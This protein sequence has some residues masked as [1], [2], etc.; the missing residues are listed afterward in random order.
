MFQEQ[1]E[2]LASVNLEHAIALIKTIIDGNVQTGESWCD[3]LIPVLSA[4]NRHPTPSI[5]CTDLIEL[6]QLAVKKEPHYSTDYRFYDELTV[7]TM[8]NMTMLQ[9]DG[10]PVSVQQ[11]WCQKA[12]SLATA[13]A[14]NSDVLHRLTSNLTVLLDNTPPPP[15]PPPP[16]QPKRSFLVVGCMMMKNESAI[17]T[18]ALNDLSPYVDTLFVVDTGSTDNSVELVKTH[19]SFQKMATAPIPSKLISVPWVN[20]GV[21]R[22]EILNGIYAH[23]EDACP[24]IHRGDL[25]AVMIDVDDRIVG[26]GSAATFR[27]EL[28]KLSEDRPDVSGAHFPV[29]NG[30]LKFIRMQAFRLSFQWKYEGALH[31]YPVCTSTPSGDSSPIFSSV[32]LRSCTSGGARSRNPFKY[33]D[34]AM[35][36]RKEFGGSNLEGDAELCEN[37]RS[38]FYLAQSFRDAGRIPAAVRFYHQRAFG[39]MNAGYRDEVDCSLQNLVHLTGSSHPQSSPNLQLRYA[40]RAFQHAWMSGSYRLEWLHTLLSTRR[41]S[42]APQTPTFTLESLALAQLAMLTHPLRPFWSPGRRSELPNSGRLFVTAAVYQWM[43][44]DEIGVASCHLKVA[45]PLG[46]FAS[47]E[48]LIGWMVLCTNK[49]PGATDIRTTTRLINNIPSLKID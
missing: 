29:H 42:S 38:C 12:I 43:L 35:V 1:F 48:A 41:L 39:L 16:F 19:P 25:W 33:W 49:T 3:L 20:F 8:H 37:P 32:F 6:A 44:A 45:G 10:V 47:Y 18:S 30:T 17:I 11:E 22:T 24:H 28:R 15:P 2:T 7:M 26:T 27:T 23:L 40:I 14:A 21:N 4:V 13:A 46:C 5:Y 31:E 9:N 34:D 36:F